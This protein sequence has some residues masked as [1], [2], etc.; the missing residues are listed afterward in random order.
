MISSAS[1]GATLSGGAALYLY[2]AR[3]GSELVFSR[4]HFANHALVT[5]EPFED[6]QGIQNFDV[7]CNP[8]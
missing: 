6:V 3:E 8:L 5:D 4:D 1:S 7:G 2:P